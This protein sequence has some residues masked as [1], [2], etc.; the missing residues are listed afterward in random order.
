MSSPSTRPGGID[1]EIELEPFE[2]TNA[3]SVHA[4]ACITREADRHVVKAD[5]VVSHRQ[6]SGA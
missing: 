5:V 6:P 1:L 2:N 3:S 4:L